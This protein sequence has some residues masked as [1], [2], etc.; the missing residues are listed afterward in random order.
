MSHTESF[1]ER[2]KP[3]VMRHE[4]FWFFVTMPENEY[5]HLNWVA[6]MEKPTWAADRLY[7][8]QTIGSRA[9]VQTLGL[10]IGE[11]RGVLVFSLWEGLE[12]SFYGPELLWHEISSAL[13]S[14]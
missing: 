10:I 4:C 3:V 6:R 2:L 12:I 14:D 8:F 7:A 5:I 11:Q 13:Y 9:G 1:F